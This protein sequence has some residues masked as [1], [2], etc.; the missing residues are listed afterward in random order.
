MKITKLIRLKCDA[1][2]IEYA[3]RSKRYRLEPVK[4][5]GHLE[6]VSAHARNQNIP[7]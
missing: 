3:V 2:N 1:Q 7:N 4:P 6:Q 5:G